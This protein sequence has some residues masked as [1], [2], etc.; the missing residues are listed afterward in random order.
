[1]QEAL[2]SVNGLSIMLESICH[3]HS[4]KYKF[5]FCSVVTR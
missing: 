1:M 3:L 2:G 4:M 5:I